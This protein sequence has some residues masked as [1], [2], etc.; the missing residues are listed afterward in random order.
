MAGNVWGTG[1]PGAMTDMA[2]MLRK[3]RGRTPDELR[4]RGMQAL[5]AGL[6]RRGWAAHARVPDDA[7]LFRKIDPARVAPAGLSAEG[8]LDHFRR[9]RSPVLTAAFTDP[10]GTRAA[11]LR[12]WPEAGRALGRRAE[13]M[14]A[15]RFDLLG[16][17]G[18]DFGRPID[19]H[20]DPVSG[21]RAPRV[22]WSRVDYHD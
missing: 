5:A 21:T 6:E 9:R 17:R 3:L 16:R 22:H 20:R 13:A 18:L 1:G 12:R 4:V 8:L 11:L 15:G 2:R 7:A 14:A 19:W 10:D